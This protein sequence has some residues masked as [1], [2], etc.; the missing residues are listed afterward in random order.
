MARSLGDPIQRLMG[1]MFKAHPWH[2]VSIGEKAP[3]GASCIVVIAA[4]A[5][6]PRRSPRGWNTSAPYVG[7][8]RIG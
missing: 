6:A 4:P 1:L 5:R 8:T 3:D 7:H 2:G